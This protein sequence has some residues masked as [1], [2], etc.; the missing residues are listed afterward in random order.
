MRLCHQLLPGE[1]GTQPAWVPHQ[2]QSWCL[3]T[4]SGLLL[5]SCVSLC[6][7][8]GCPAFRIGWIQTQ[9]GG[10]TVDRMYIKAAPSPFW[11]PAPTDSED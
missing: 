5:P 7:S 2:E 1:S 10:E 4:C 8:S 6:P 11:V 3:V 9:K